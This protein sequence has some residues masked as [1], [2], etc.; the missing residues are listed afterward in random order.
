[1]FFFISTGGE[2][3]E[4]SQTFLTKNVSVI[5]ECSLYFPGDWNSR[6]WSAW[7]QDLHCYVL[8]LNFL[9]CT[10]ATLPA[11]FWFP[12]HAPGNAV[13]KAISWRDCGFPIPC[14]SS[15]TCRPRSPSLQV[16]AHIFVS[17]KVWKM[18]RR[19]SAQLLL[20]PT[21]ILRPSMMERLYF[22]SL[23]M[24]FPSFPCTLRFLLR[25]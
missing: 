16:V 21:L 12:E 22:F 10:F 19:V 1:M 20:F 2:F 18:L 25:C 9:N 23:W 4:E 5:K 14:P 13:L 15:F 17:A 7:Q 24:L 8:S 6:K 3:W 11:P